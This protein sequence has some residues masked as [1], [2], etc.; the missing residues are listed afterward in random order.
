MV[1]SPTRI[2]YPFFAAANVADPLEHGAF[3]LHQVRFHQHL[4]VLVELRATLGRLDAEL[5]DAVL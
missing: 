3:D 4:G 2:A 5:G 1:K